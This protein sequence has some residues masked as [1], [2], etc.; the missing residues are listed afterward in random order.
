MWFYVILAIVATAALLA[1]SNKLRLYI[2]AKYAAWTLGDRIVM[3]DHASA[4]ADIIICINAT[5]NKLPTRCRRLQLLINQAHI[6]GIKLPHGLIRLATKALEDARIREGEAAK[7]VR[8]A[9]PDGAAVDFYA[10]KSM[11]DEPDASFKGPFNDR[12]KKIVNQSG[13]VYD[14]VMWIAVVAF[15]RWQNQPAHGLRRDLLRASKLVVKG[16]AAIGKFL[17]RSHNAATRQEIYELFIEGGDNDLSI[18]FANWP[19]G[20]DEHSI[21][22]VQTDIMVDFFNVLMNV[23]HEYGLADML[24]KWLQLP[25]GTTIGEDRFMFDEASC[26]SFSIDDYAHIDG[27]D[28]KRLSRM[29]MEDERVYMTRA[30]LDF[31]ANNMRSNFFLARIL[32]AYRVYGIDG[33][34]MPVRAELLDVSIISQYNTPR[35]AAYVPVNPVRWVG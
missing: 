17:L 5:N 28:Y 11:F 24:H 1:R 18:R 26:A 21:Y 12:L 34:S 25:V 27:V 33:R 10:A 23:Y 13:E 22:Q 19:A 16:G 31:S 2:T 35:G 15:Y 30:M 32:A 14:I 9:M 8:L 29:S 7:P 20:A 6:D 3:M 4:I